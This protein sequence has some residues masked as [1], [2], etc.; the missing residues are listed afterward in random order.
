[1]DYYEMTRSLIRYLNNLVSHDRWR[2]KFDAPTTIVIISDLYKILLDILS[3]HVNPRYANLLDIDVRGMYIILDETKNVS[4]FS[5]KKA[6]RYI[7]IVYFLYTQLS[8]N[9]LMLWSLL[10]KICNIIRED[11]YDQKR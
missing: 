9:T 1:M 2:I 7:H 8:S 10:D 6:L 3:E 4:L 5:D 11:K